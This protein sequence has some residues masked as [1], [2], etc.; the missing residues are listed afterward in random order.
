MHND[1]YCTRGPL[2]GND[3]A[4]VIYRLWG[5][6]SVLSARVGLSGAD[7]ENRGQPAWEVHTGQALN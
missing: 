6:R 5:S 1:Y 3:A 2:D 4:Q 7:G